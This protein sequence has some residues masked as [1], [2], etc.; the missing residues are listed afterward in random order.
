MFAKAP[1]SRMLSVRLILLA[2]WI[3]LIVSLFWDPVTVSLT[4]P[5]SGTPFRIKDTPVAV[6]GQVLEQKPYAMGARMFWTM[7]LPCVP[8]FMMLF[9]HEAWRRI[10]PLSLSSRIPYYLKFQWMRKVFN[11]QTGRVE[12][13]AAVISQ[14]SFVARWHFPLQFM[15]LTAG[16]TAR[17]LFIN[18]DRSA[19][20]FFFIGIIAAA[21]ITGIFYAGK[22]WC[23]YFCPI[24]TI[25]KIY[26]SPRGVLESKAHTPKQLVS[27]SMCRSIGKDGDQPACVACASPCPD[28]DLER[29][30]WETYTQPGTRFTYYGYTGM[31]LMFYVYYYL[32]SGSWDYYFSGA[33]THEE[34]AQMNQLMNPGF[35]VAGMLVPIP[36]ILAAP[37]AML[38]C[39][40]ATYA[41]WCGVEWI[42]TRIARKVKPAIGDDEIR[43]HMLIIC[44]WA[45]I[46]IFYL[47]A[48]RPNIALMPH[49]LQTT[50][51]TFIVT[52]TT[53][54]MGRNILRKATDHTDESLAA[55]LRIRLKQAGAAIK[56]YTRG[57][58][59]D[60]LSA[61]EVNVLAK[62]V[63]TE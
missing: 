25:Q 30:Y 41:F 62:V 23:N 16:V 47:F 1:E 31:V 35:F 19:L 22:T 4:E 48:G 7:V 10:C 13:K 2:A 44:A 58:T 46:N 21:F 43:H 54:W 49:W 14:D 24:A 34:N 53:I 50:I 59:V 15:F 45:T 36:K 28:I 37:L 27:Q 57:R 29:T 52:V 8:L 40:F 17:L 6:Q 56:E 51:N 9:G 33:W 55:T 12:R 60:E 42:Y 39:I 61:G 5:N 3:V 38:A 32:Y 11:R 26:T 20:A 63:K 18:S